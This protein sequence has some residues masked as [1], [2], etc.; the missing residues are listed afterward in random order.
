M[1][2]TPYLIFG[3]RCREAF[4]AYADILGGAITATMPWEGS[5]KRLRHCR[6]EVRGQ[7]LH[8]MDSQLGEGVQG[9]ALMLALDTPEEAERVFTGLTVGGEVT[10]PMGPTPFAG[11]FGM[12]VDAFGMRWMVTGPEKG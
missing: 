9:A 3:G 6:L 5:D 11:R 8:G 12:G 4:T 1:E 7:V 2:L 10:V